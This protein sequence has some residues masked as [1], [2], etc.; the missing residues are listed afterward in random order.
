[1]FYKIPTRVEVETVVTRYALYEKKKTTSTRRSKQRE[2]I[3]RERGKKVK[4]KQLLKAN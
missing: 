1:M 2:R 3:Y 4:K